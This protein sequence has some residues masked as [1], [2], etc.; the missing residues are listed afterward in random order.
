MKVRRGGREGGREGECQTLQLSQERAI[1]LNFP[2]SLPPFFCTQAASFPSA[3]KTFLP[4]GT[5]KGRAALASVTCGREGGREGGRERGREEGLA[6]N[7]GYRQARG[8][9]ERRDLLNVLC[10]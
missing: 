5:T 7:R 9:E 2:P 10:L 4:S 1:H 3:L 8:R 6:G